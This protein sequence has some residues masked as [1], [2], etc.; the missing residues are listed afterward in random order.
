MTLQFL[1]IPTSLCF[2]V[3]ESNQFVWSLNLNRVYVGDGYA[4]KSLMCHGSPVASWWLGLAQ[5]YID[6]PSPRHG[7][8]LKM[9]NALGCLWYPF[10]N[11]QWCNVRNLVDRW[12]KSIIAI[13]MDGLLPMMGV[14]ISQ[15]LEGLCLVHPPIN[16]W[17]LVVS[18]H[19]P[20]ITIC[21]WWSE[22]FFPKYLGMVGWL[23]NIFQR[24]YNH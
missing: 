19:E 2:P 4:M 22:V 3:R 17:V 1:V 8:P 12:C 14:L 24:G 16:R 9:V 6:P 13:S 7:S 11:S 21:S 10:L 18:H 23:T 15:P 20:T 5:K